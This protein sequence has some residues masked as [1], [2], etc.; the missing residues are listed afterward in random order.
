MKNY[1]RNLVLCAAISLAGCVTTQDFQIAPNMVRLDTSAMGRGW[2]SD[3]GHATQVAAAQA[4]K[5]YGFDLFKF[6][7]VQTGSGVQYGGQLSSG[8]A[9]FSASPYSA[10]GTANTFSSP[11]MV[12][13]S[14]IGV[15]VIMFHRG[16]KGSDGA[17]DAD[18]I[19]QGSG[20]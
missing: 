1:A 14:H 20:G 15:T 13:T 5:K 18:K 19:L 6:A 17:F 10:F 7:D 16:E 4:T 11:V 8:S 12:D 2:V 3:A 9:N